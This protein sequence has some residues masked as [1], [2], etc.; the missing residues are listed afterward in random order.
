MEVDETTHQTSIRE[1]QEETGIEDIVF[2][3]DFEELDYY[4]LFFGRKSKFEKSSIYK[5]LDSYFDFRT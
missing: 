4:R 3:N 1:T 2:L 5:K